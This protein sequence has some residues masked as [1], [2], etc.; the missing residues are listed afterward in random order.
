MRPVSLLSTFFPIRPALVAWCVALAVSSLACSFDFGITRV[1]T[2]ADGSLLV[3]ADNPQLDRFHSA[4]GGLTWQPV[5]DTGLNRQDRIAWGGAAV[6]TPRGSYSINGAEITRTHGGE[7]ET[8]YSA[9]YLRDAANRVLQ[10]RAT[11]VVLTT[12]PLGIA[13]DD[14]SGNVI[15]AMG[16]QGVVVGGGD[17]IWQRVAVHRYAPTDFSVSARMGLLWSLPAFWA[18]LVLFLTSFPALA[19]ILARCRRREG[20]AATA[21]IAL[22]TGAIHV[23]YQPAPDDLLADAAPMLAAIVIA[24]IAGPTAGFLLHRWPAGSAKRRV[25]SLMAVGFPTAW[26]VLTFPRLGPWADGGAVPFGFLVLV[27]L[28]LAIMAARPYWENGKQWR[29]LLITVAATMVVAMAPTL[30]WLLY[31]ISGAQAGWI[32]VLAA[33]AVAFVLFWHLKRRQ[34]VERVA[35]ADAGG[36]G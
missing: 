25:L 20:I 15:V 19:I 2:S 8:A 9:A 7:T 36:T 3:Q 21:V 4:N 32:S 10:H 5:P 17:G 14:R 13:Y 23:L 24:L 27:A 26:V 31:V 29:V 1:G 30:L 35:S 34:R 12:A 16:S 18:M 11:S 28:I 6:S 22:V 33:W